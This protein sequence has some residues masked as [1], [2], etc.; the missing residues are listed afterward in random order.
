[1]I[2]IIIKN[3]MTIKELNL[4]LKNK[5][6]T[7][8]QLV[9][10]YF[11]KIDKIDKNIDAYLSLH[12]EKA[13]EKAK[14][15]DCKWDFSNLLTWIPFANKAIICIKD[16]EC[17]ASSKI[18]EW[19]KPVEN[20]TVINKLKGAISLGNV[21]CDEFAQWSSTENSWI[22]ITKNPNDLTKVPWGSSWWSAAAV[23]AD[24]CVFSLWTDTWGSIRQPAAF[25]WV[26]WL[27]PTYG[28]VSR[29]WVMSYGSSFD[30]IG[31]ITKT[32]EDAAI[33]LEQ[34]AGNDK[35]DLTTPNVEVPK[36]SE[37]L[38]VNIKGRKIAFLKEF[39]NAEALDPKIKENIEWVINQL[40]K[41]WVEFEEVSIPELN[42][43]IQTYYLLVKSE[44]S[45]NLHRYDGIRY[46]HTTENAHTIKETFEK[47]RT[48]WFGQEVIRCIMLGT[49]ALSSWYY[50]AYYLKAAKVRRLIKES[51]DKVFEKFDAIIAPVS[52]FLPFNIGE[53]TEDPLAMYL[54][55]FY[56][57]PANLAGI[58]SISI[59]TGTIDNLPTAVQIMGKQFDEL[60]IMQIAYSI[61]N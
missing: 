14:E 45:T 3:N 34:I 44:A 29:S 50:D 46:G 39:M 27:K 35:N 26:V 10:E 37:N 30:T 42:Y 20:A 49:Y 54:A 33:I 58:P 19:Y 24:E 5:E 9:E 51:F 53:K 21:N 23:A 7:A 40:K 28:R 18:L 41:E 13:L 48:E 57:V 60:W 56:T 52:P 43:A 8:V 2:L 36:Y 38:D 55:D 1:M 22:K 6:I 59:P 4:K 16:E 15:I 32:V 12:K 61:T 17:N 25:C 11:E 31:P 47:S